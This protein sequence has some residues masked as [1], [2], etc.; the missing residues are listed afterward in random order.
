MRCYG[1]TSAAGL[2]TIKPTGRLTQVKEAVG[3]AGQDRCATFNEPDRS[4]R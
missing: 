1:L 2:T 4:N 3:V